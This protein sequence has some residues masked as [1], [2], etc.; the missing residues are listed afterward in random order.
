M[1]PVLGVGVFGY[2]RPGHITSIIGQF[3]VMV[4]LSVLTAFLFFSFSLREESS[5][6]LARVSPDI[7]DVLIAFLV[8]WL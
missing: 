6:F 1:G 5:E 3:C 4:L 2:Q 7:R 8:V